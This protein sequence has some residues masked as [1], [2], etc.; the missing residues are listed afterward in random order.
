M[1][2]H[3]RMLGCHLGEDGEQLRVVYVRSARGQVDADPR[4]GVGVVELGDQ[5]RPGLAL[6]GSRRSQAAGI[7]LPSTA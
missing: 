7:E 6:L 5:L 2:A 3:P 1:Q 4:L